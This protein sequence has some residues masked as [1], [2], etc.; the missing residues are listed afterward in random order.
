MA[1]EVFPRV[2]VEMDR[3]NIQCENLAIFLPQ[4]FYVN[5]ISVSPDSG[6]LEFHSVEI[7]KFLSHSFM[8][9]LL[10]N[11]RENN[12]L[13][14]SYSK[15]ALEMAQFSIFRANLRKFDPF[16]LIEEGLNY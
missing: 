4:R 1:L 6:V 12:V 3:G 8:W 7:T 11:F 15:M 13:K 16:G 2:Y 14:A 9:K 10:K 5:S